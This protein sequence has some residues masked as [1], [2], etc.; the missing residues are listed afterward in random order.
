[1]G[2]GVEDGVP[3]ARDAGARA[4]A[5]ASGTSAGAIR[6][7]T[8]GSRSSLG[9]SREYGV[10]GIELSQGLRWMW[11]STYGRS[12][13]AYAQATRLASTTEMPSKGG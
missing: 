1:M 5:D 2:E 9:S 8:S 4:G 3:A 12:P 13:S 7:R 11:W 6:K 10:D